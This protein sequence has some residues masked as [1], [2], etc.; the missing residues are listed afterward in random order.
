M[1]NNR[2]NGTNA[3]APS[4]EAQARAAFERVRAACPEDGAVLG[5]YLAAIHQKNIIAL[6]NGEAFALTDAEGR[7]IKATKRTVR[8]SAKNGGL[9]Q[10]VFRGPYVIS[11]PGYSMLAHAAGAVVMNAPTVT[12]DGIQQ[13]NPYVRRG[14]DGA[15]IEV[16]CRA[17]AFRY[18]ENGQPMVSDRTTIFDT[19]TYALADMVGKAKRAKDAF[20]LLPAAIPAPK[21]AEDWACYRVD[22][23]VN[24]W[25]RISHEEVISFLGQVLNRKKKALEFAQTFAQRNALKH[26][27]GIA[28]VPGQA[29]GPISVW[30]VPV[31]CWAPSDGGLIRF[32]TARYAASTQIIEALT[33]GKPVALPEAQQPIVISRGA[34]EVRGADMDEEAD[35]L[36]NP[37]R[38]ESQESGTVMS[39]PMEEPAVPMPE[40]EQLR[41]E[42]APDWTAEEL[43]AWKNLQVAREEFPAEYEDALA[44]CGLRDEEVNPGNAAEINRAISAMLDAG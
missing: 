23:A 13:Q 39:P 7:S 41:E 14:P 4:L 3:P 19:A 43:A 16:H 18:N 24:L 8:L 27:F 20:K 21:P 15:I 25:M 17:M 38:Y 35:P 30:D 28:V 32:D 44:N 9:T 29:N 36:E 10:P 1:N 12:V 6:G 37:D 22:E 42:P 2:Q 26:L 34:D 40:R 33:E 11:A 31:V 5:R